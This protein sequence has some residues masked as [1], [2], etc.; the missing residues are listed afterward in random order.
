MITRIGFA[1]GDVW[2]Y[3]DNHHNR[4]TQLSKIV[5]SLDHPRD[6]LLMSVGWLAREGHLILEPRDGDYWVHL[7]RPEGGGG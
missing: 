4:A 1:A 7:R 6:V 5:A 3:L 2:Q